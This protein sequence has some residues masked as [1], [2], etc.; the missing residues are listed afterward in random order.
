MD[1]AATYC[2]CPAKVGQV[3]GEMITRQVVIE[4][5]QSIT[6]IAFFYIDKDGQQIS[7]PSVV[8]ENGLFHVTYP[9]APAE[10]FIQFSSYDPATNVYNTDYR[11][12]VISF[13][14]LYNSP[15]GLIVMNK[16]GAGSTLNLPLIFAG[17]AFGLYALSASRKKKVGVINFDRINKMETG[18]KILLA[19]GVLVGGYLLIKL[20]FGYRPTPQQKKT[21]EDAKN[22][23]DKLHFEDGID[24]TM[25]LGQFS[26]L[27]SV[28]KNASVD[29][30]TDESAIYHVINQLNNDADVYQ[31][32]VSADI[33]SY[34][35]CAATEGHWFGNV[36]YTV[37]ELIVSE[38]TSYEVGN[39]NNILSSKGINYRF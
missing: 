29:C 26:S 30:G 27:A 13:H 18:K 33:L 23:L 20:L 24:I 34:K 3:A 25:S 12:R 10:I 35:S 28:L 17:S 36:H 4:S 16:P 11:S 21:I 31:L 6:N 1:T 15:D 9:Q 19:G 14:E 22:M 2:P 37:P 38:L 7:S 5:G 39:V 32:I 8:D